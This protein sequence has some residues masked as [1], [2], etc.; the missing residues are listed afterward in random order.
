MNVKKEGIYVPS[1]ES[2]FIFEEQYQ[3]IRI[4]PFIKCRSGKR[5]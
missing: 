1:H 5:L 4:V 3:K 2:L